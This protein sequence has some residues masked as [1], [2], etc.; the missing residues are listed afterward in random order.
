MIV[1]AAMLFYKRNIER[2]HYD[3]CNNIVDG[4]P[5]DDAIL[6]RDWI[7]R[8]T[9]NPQ[10]ERVDYFKSFA[11]ACEVLDRDVAAERKRLLSEIDARADYHSKAVEAR[12]RAIY[13]DSPDPE[14][15]FEGMRVVPEVDQLRMY[16]PQAVEALI[17]GPKKPRKPYTRRNTSATGLKLV[18]L[19]EHIEDVE[20]VEAA[21]RFI[22]AAESM[23]TMS[24]FG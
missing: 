15:R 8:P 7:A 13:E 11:Y 4:F 10:E 19:V 23:E 1:S 21:E 16:G 9:P 22:E 17:Q 24:M 3:A 2:A 14:E 20:V 5:E 12:L 18:D 6:A